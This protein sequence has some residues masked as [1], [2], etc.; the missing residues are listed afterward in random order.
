M[1][2]TSNSQSRSVELSGSTSMKSV[3]NMPQSPTQK[4]IQEIVDPQVQAAPRP[5]DL[6][7]ESLY[8]PS[9]TSTRVSRSSIFG[10]FS[11]LPLL[12]R[13]RP[14]TSASTTSSNTATSQRPSGSLSKRLFQKSHEEKKV[15]EDKDK[16]E[17]EN[18]QS[19]RKPRDPVKTVPSGK[20]PAVTFA[21]LAYRYGSPSTPIQRRL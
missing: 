16:D 3:S 14:S 1:S 5:R 4:E 8:A 18:A 12:P 20:P 21:D 2:N 7:S 10:S 6:E 19:K 15:Q 13:S 11:K 17:T 9:T